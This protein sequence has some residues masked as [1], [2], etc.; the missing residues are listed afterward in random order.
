MDWLSDSINWFAEQFIVIGEYLTYLV[1]WISE[2]IYNLIV[3]AY[4][5]VILKV[6]QFRWWWF[7]E[8]LVFAWDVAEQILSDLDISSKLQAAWSGLDAE[9]LRWVSF[10]R[11]PE[12]VN[13]LLNAVATS[14]VMSRLR[15]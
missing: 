2:E 1:Y 13:V 8:S 12:C 4:A 9:T 15:F 14:F 5:W 3:E 6:E 10:F 11:I 7:R